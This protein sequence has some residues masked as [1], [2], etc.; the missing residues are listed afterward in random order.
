MITCDFTARGSTPLYEHLYRSIRADIERGRLKADQRLPSK[1]S[2]A[3]QL[4]IGVVTVENAYAQLLSEGYIR[5]A[6]R[7]GY[8]VN[9][10]EQGFPNRTPARFSENF[11]LQRGEAGAE[12]VPAKSGKEIGRASC[13]ERVYA[14]V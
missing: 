12:A 4:K 14:C 5:S 8:F 1:R 2:L 10:L 9:R 6:E 13:R 7:R 3:Q 11:Q